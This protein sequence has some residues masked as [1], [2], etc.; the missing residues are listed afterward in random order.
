MQHQKFGPHSN[1]KQHN[2]GVDIEVN[3]NDKVIASFDG[4]VAFVGSNIKSFGNMILIKHDK[5]WITAYSKVGKSLVAQG[6][7]VKK[8]DIIASME[9]NNILHFQI[10]KSRNPINPET[11]LN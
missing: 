6:D 10:R 2:D 1:G 7:L 5:K 9:D 3:E 8:G 11:L 4:K